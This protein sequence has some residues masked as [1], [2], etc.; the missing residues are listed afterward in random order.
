MELEVFS[1]RRKTITLIGTYILFVVLL[2][3]ELY[4][5]AA[6]SGAVWGVSLLSSVLYF[7]FYLIFK[8]PKGTKVALLQ[9]VMVP[10]RNIKLSHF[11]AFS[12]IYIVYL[13]IGYG[14]RWL[15]S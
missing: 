2:Y 7:A 14:F 5:P 11:V 6:T 4:N 3:V 10:N 8:S 1:K 13:L 9:G 12:V 15:A